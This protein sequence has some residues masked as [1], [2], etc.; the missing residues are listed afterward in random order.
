VLNEHGEPIGAISVSGPAIRVARE[1]LPQIGALVRA[2]AGEL[3]LELGGRAATPVRRDLWALSAAKD[4]AP[5]RRRAAIG[6]F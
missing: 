4:G 5:P 1:R 3:T 6:I 2:I